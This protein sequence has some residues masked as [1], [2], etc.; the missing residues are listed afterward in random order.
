MLED[1]RKFG[2]EKEIYSTEFFDFVLG[3]QKV[4]LSLEGD[5]ET[6]KSL[7][8]TAFEVGGKA[9]LEVLSKAKANS[10][11]DEHVSILV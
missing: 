8:R 4:V 3:L 6:T 5:D 7:R 10:S 11:L 2:F 1:N 9:T